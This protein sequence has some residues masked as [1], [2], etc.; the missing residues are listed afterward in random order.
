[1]VKFLFRING[2]TKRDFLLGDDI[3]VTAAARCVNLN[4][5]GDFC[6]CHASILFSERRQWIHVEEIQ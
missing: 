5:I 4:G 3:E 2:K 1:M 6:C